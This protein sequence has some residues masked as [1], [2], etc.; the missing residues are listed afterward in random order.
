MPNETTEPVIAVNN[1]LAVWPFDSVAAPAPQLSHAQ[2]PPLLLQSVGTSPDA[3][4]M[5]G[6]RKLY[7][8]CR[9]CIAL[10]GGDAIVVSWRLYIRGCCH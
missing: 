5:C 3:D 2:K 4:M 10:E 7:E 6:V 1:V 8:R 9:Y